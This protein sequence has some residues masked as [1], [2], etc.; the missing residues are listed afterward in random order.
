MSV[1]CRHA[2]E[3]SGA[4]ELETNAK[5]ILTK[6]GIQDFYASIG[7]LSG[8]YRKRIALAAAPL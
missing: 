2:A 4:W 1:I 8:G 3:V 7:S 5:I 6:L